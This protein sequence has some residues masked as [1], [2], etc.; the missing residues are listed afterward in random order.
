MNYSWQKTLSKGQKEIGYIEIYETVAN[1]ISIRAIISYF[2]NLN[3]FNNNK[4]CSVS[5]AYSCKNSD[6]TSGF[7]H[8]INNDITQLIQS[9][10]DICFE[11]TMNKF[12]FM[13][14]QQFFVK[15]L[16]ELEYY[17]H[18]DFSTE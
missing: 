16:P 1:N 2:P 17:T 18:G 13:M 5:I 6:V 4:I 14:T 9:N 3:Q 11:S 12:E 15:K 7:F 8:S 10:E